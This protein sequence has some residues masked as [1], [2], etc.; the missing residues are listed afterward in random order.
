[1][2][3][4]SGTLALKHKIQPVTPTGVFGKIL[5]N[6]L[7]VVIVL[8]LIATILVRLFKP[9]LASVQVEE[10]VTTTLSQLLAL[11][12]PYLAYITSGSTVREYAKTNLVQAIGLALVGTLILYGIVTA[13]QYFFSIGPF[14]Q[15]SSLQM[16]LSQTADGVLVEAVE[17]GG[18]A[19]LAGVQVGD[20]ITAVRRDAVDLNML[21]QMISRSDL[22]TPLRL[23]I[24]RGGEELQLTART[25]LDANVNTGALVS[26]L[27]VA[28]IITVAAIFFPGNWTPYILLSLILAPLMLGYLWL[29]IATFS[30]RTQGIIPLDGQ[31]NIGGWTLSNWD[32]LFGRDIV[33]LNIS[34]WQITLNSLI[35]A[36]S[37]TVIVL[38]VSSMAGYAL[39]RMNFKGR[40]AF[41]SFTLVLHGFPAVT[42]LIPIFFVLAYMGNTPIIGN[43]IGFNKP[44]GIALIMVAFEL[45]LG[46]WLMKGY[47]DGIPW[48]IE[49]SALIDGASRWRV[50]WEI[51]LPQIR[52]GILAL[53]IFSF[54]AGWNAFLV[55]QTY[56]IG[57]GTVNL[58]VF[59]SQLISE[60]S[61]VNWNQVAAVGLF[62][63]IPVFV[64]FIFAQE[65][66][67]NI[68]A[69]GTKGSS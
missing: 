61:P 16:T 52:P 45:P 36:I 54:I 50:Y 19:E 48:D 64:I 13:G 10:T 40:R 49:R 55:P 33:G 44:I 26:G 2:T 46:T 8:A 41:L 51:L 5:R 35:M 11:L 47:F 63:L 60:T 57:T 18:A 53:G 25:V 17:S 7:I 59:L 34:I 43:F 12:L 39:S 6:G 14:A 9:L 58:P 24:M 37:M 69:G 1:M 38:L 23:R 56:S 30:Y 27:V 15:T 66:L 29:I 65:Y 4:A 62:Q 21:T 22:D 42:L 3:S 28:L 67:L 20:L 68:Y 32:F 31:N